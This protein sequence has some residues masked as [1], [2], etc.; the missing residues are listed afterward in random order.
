M[1]R[2]ILVDAL[3]TVAVSSISLPALLLLIGACYA[4]GSHRVLRWP[5]LLVAIAHVA[6]ELSIVSCALVALGL[7]DIVVQKL[8]PSKT[9]SRLL[10]RLNSATSWA[11]FHAAASQLDVESKIS[12]WKGISQDPAYNADLVQVAVQRLRAARASEDAIALLDALS[13]C[14]RKSFAGIDHEALYSRCFCGT[15]RL[16]EL[17]VDEVVAALGDVQERIG[18]GDG[19]FDERAR[20]FLYRA[21][22]VFGR[23]ALTLSGGG[24]L[25]N[26]SWG[27]VKALHDQKMLPSL[28]CGTSAGAVVAAAVCTHTDSELDGLL[29]ADTLQQ[30]L[31]SFEE[32]RSVVIR[33]MLRFGHMYDARSWKPKIEALCNQAKV[34]NMTFQEAF[35]RTGRE[36]CVT[37]TARRRH[38]PPLVLSRLSAPDVTIASAVLATVAM[39]FLVPAQ[40]LVCKSADGTL[41]PWVAGSLVSDGK[42]DSGTDASRTDH[43]TDAGEWRDGSIVHD[44]PRECLAQHFG[45]SFTVASQ[46]N[47]HVVPLFIGLRPTAGQPAVSRLQRGRDSWRGG[48]ALSALLVVLLS[49]AK[50]WLTVMRELEIMPLILDTDWSSLMLQDFTGDITIIPPLTLRDYL[51]VLAD[52]DMPMMERYLQVG[53][54]ECW[55][56]LPMLTTRLKIASALRAVQN[57][58]ADADVRTGTVGA[59]TSLEVESGAESDSHGRSGT[60][61]MAARSLRRT[62]SK[63]SF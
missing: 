6:V 50:K 36:L 57:A 2:S 8:R 58:L 4:F 25:S 59:D 11:A 43:V 52:P 63:L 48:F 12:V 22:R 60:T 56:K 30:L 16:I 3:S 37:V 41:R 32:P 55:R 26:Y 20:N 47:P 39:P 44:T 10:E 54:R 33:R 19:R 38:E 61:P 15:K 14:V 23:T 45:A 40:A 21:Q 46:C 7:W 18:Q 51:R 35:K 28:I 17:Y 5:V 53:Q 31:T 27:V 42:N 49:D 62:D 13:V 29:R 9:A 34:A 24:A 1:L